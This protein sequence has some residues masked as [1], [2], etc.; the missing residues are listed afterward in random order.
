M[1][2]YHINIED[3]SA[4]L[5]KLNDG[6]FQVT[7]N[8][9]FG[10]LLVGTNY[11]LAEKEFAEYLQALDIQ[12]V[13]YKQ[14]IIWNRRANEEYK[15]HMELIISHHFNS[16]DIHDI[17]TEGNQFL[18]MNNSYLFVS[19]KLKQELEKSKYKFTYTE[20]LNHFA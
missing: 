15:N 12:R 17:N 11:V 1:N 13:S 19:Q 10:Q 20:G 16:S 6:R 2:P 14:A 4:E 5:Y 3:K 18:I 9:E 7:K 8:G